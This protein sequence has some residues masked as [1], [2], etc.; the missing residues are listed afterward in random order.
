MHKDIGE[1]WSC[2]S[3]CYTTLD[4]SV[5]LSY[6]IL[7][8]AF[9][10]VPSQHTAV[11]SR[12]EEPQHM[13]DFQKFNL[14]SFIFTET[15]FS[16][17]YRFSLSPC[18]SPVCTFTSSISGADFYKMHHCTLFIAQGLIYHHWIPGSCHCIPFKAVRICHLK[19]E[20]HSAEFVPGAVF[21]QCCFCSLS[22]AKGIQ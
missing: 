9:N 18:A 19:L 14:S 15:L 1:I 22:R 13:T 17:S 6:S 21:L 12:T 11:C 8:R 7:S 4:N 20:Y 2:V 3:F 5:K 10:G 16:A